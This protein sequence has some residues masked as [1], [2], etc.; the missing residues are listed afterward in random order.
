MQVEWKSCDRLS[1]DNLKH[2]FY[3]THNLWE[4]APPPSLTVYF[5]PLRG[6]YIQMS[7][8]P[9]TPK[10]ESQNWDSCCPKTLDLHIFLKSNI[11]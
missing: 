9:D 8:F 1:K 5:V 4:E 3:T 6:D 7:L 2:K 11:F 10:W